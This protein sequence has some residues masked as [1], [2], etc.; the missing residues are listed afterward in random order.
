MKK[1][2]NHSTNFNY[3]ELG[4]TQWLGLLGYAAPSVSSLP[5]HVHEFFNYLEM[6]GVSHIENVLPVHINGFVHHLKQRHNKTYGGS[7]SS[8][9]IN[10]GIHSLST[11]SRYLNS[12]G[13]F[14]IDLNRRG[15]P[16][17][18]NEPVVLT[19]EE[20]QALY[21]ST[22]LSYDFNDIATGQRD[23]AIIA[24]FYGCG[25]RRTEGI[26]LN[27]FDIDLQKGMLFVRRGKGNKQRHV[28][29]AR[30]HL[31]DIKAYITEG[32]RWY[33]E[34]HYC[35]HYINKRYG[36]PFP[37]K[38]HT[39]DEAFFL[40]LRGERMNDFAYRLKCMKERAGIDKDFSLHKL[41]HSI[42][43]HL[44]ESGMDLEQIAKFLGHSSLVSTQIYTHIVNTQQ[45]HTSNESL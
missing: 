37:K 32:R 28:P 22:F 3:L 14:T 30:K 23:R 35:G 27:L 20:I 5:L 33:M 2:I 7:L 15:I 40:N 45:K 10:K 11:F 19:K 18:A 41:R 13:K 36:T 39:D 44:L 34:D 6:Q 17:D 16:N 43:T 29:I 26:N 25:L 12:T 9:Y 21:D 31:E 4:F 42:A 1:L 8:A 24:V 38:L